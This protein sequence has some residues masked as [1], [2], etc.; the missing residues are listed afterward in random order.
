MK[1]KTSWPK[2]KKQCRPKLQVIVSDKHQKLSI[3]NN[4]SSV[5]KDRL[6]AL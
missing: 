6:G 4:D 5:A 2:K 1:L 3:I